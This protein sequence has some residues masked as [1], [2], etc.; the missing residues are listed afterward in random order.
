MHRRKRLYTSVKS[1]VLLQYNQNASNFIKTVYDSFI[2]LIYIL[3]Q[4]Q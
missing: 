2:H 3:C 4:T 1:V